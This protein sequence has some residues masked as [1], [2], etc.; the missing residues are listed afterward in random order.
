MLIFVSRLYLSNF[1]YKSFNFSITS[2]SIKQQDSFKYSIKSGY[3]YFKFNINDKVLLI[4]V[5]GESLKK[6]EISK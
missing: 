2:F 4:K 5:E 6:L 3:S 1:S